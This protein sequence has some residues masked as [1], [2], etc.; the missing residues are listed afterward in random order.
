[1]NSEE[2]FQEQE[3]EE[4]EQKVSVLHTASPLSK[5]LA[6]ILFIT[7]PFVG[8]WIGYKYSPEKVVEVERIVI[9]QVV[10][11]IP[12]QVTEL[13]KNNSASS[14]IIFSNPVRD[15]A[16]TTYEVEN[17]IIKGEWNA[18]YG[19]NIHGGSHINFQPH[20]TPGPIAKR[21]GVRN[22]INSTSSLF[23]VDFLQ[24][25]MSSEDC[26]LSGGI[27]TIKI[28]KYNVLE[29]EMGA[30][31]YAVVDEVVSFTASTTKNCW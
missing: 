16:Y 10:V 8:G 19:P 4:T 17:G 14:E 30:T 11:E 18:M 22:D 21:F 29:A 31:D 1:M 24:L 27:A 28:S 20:E 13:E 6:M 9:Q 5:Y 2:N 25:E 3:I 15:G 23:D 26:N 7:L 12:A